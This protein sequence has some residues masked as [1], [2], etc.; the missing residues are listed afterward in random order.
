MSLLA[1]ALQPHI[2]RGL[3]SLG[4]RPEG[5]SL[6][7]LLIR[8]GVAYDVN[9]SLENNAVILDFRDPTGILGAVASDLC[10]LSSASFQSVHE[11]T[12]EVENKNGMPWAFVKLYYAA[13]YAGHS[14]M[15]LLGESCS[16]FEAKHVQRISEVATA[17]GRSI[18]ALRAG[19]YRC[20]LNASASGMNCSQARGSVGGAHE[21]FWSVFG[22]M[23]EAVSKLVLTGSMGRADA[24][25]VF[26]KLEELRSVIGQIRGYSWLSGTRNAIQYRHE[27]GVWFPTQ[28]RAGERQKLGRLAAKWKTDP[29]QLP[30]STK[31]GDLNTFVMGSIFIIAVCRTMLLRIAERSTA[32]ARPFVEFGPIALLHQMGAK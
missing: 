2:T 13:F 20:V 4:G 17:L 24:Q 3:I 7:E 6:P 11:I 9:A 25:A 27:H 31:D 22:N 14:I 1:D 30:L 32:N 26:T 28:Y 21:A 29:M 23:L 18:P 16:Y 19:F 10:R 15:R 12:P 5:F 8:R